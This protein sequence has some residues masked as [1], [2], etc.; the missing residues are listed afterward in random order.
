[1]KRILLS[2]LLA[3]SLALPALGAKQNVLD[4]KET[5]TDESIVYPETFERDTR[6]LLEGWYLKNYTATDDRYARQGDVEVSDETIKR[7][8]AALPTVIDMPYNQIVRDYI[9]RYTSRSREQVAAILGLGLYYTPIFEQALEEAGLP[10]ELKYLPVIES[11][12]DPNAVSKSGAAGLWQLMI[13]TAKGLG[14]EVNSLVDE[15]RDPYLSSE[16]AVA[17]LKDL[18]ET[19]GDWSLAIAAYNCGPGAVNKALRRAGGDPKSH[20]FWSI[21]QYLTPETRGYVPMFIAA[22]YVMNY[23]KEH[24]ISPVLASKPLVTDT[25]AVY[26][27]L[28]FNQISDVLNMPVDELRIL[29]PQF[30]ADVIPADSDRPYFLILP[31]Q[32]VHAYLVSEQE[33]FAHEADKYARRE[34]AEP[35]QDA[36][37]VAYEPAPADNEAEQQQEVEMVRKAAAQSSGQKAVTHKVASGETITSIAQQYGVTAADIK[38]WNNLRRNAVRTGQQLKIYT[39]GEV[40][41]QTAPAKA[42]EQPVAAANP[43][44]KTKK[45]ED[46]P[47]EQPVAKKDDKKSG[48]AGKANAKAEEQQAANAKQGKKG[49][50]AKA[51]QQAANTKQ[52]KKGKK[53]KQPAAP[54]NKDIEVKSGDNLSK[55][56]KRNGVSVEELRKANPKLKGDMLHPGDKITVPAKQQPAKGNGKAA[57]KGGKKKKK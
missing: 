56:A 3:A 15:R 29:N 31:S 32:Q 27:R 50:K 10:L 44:T 9:K 51:E 57:K 7:R 30:R 14:L 21:Y 17:Y 40:A 34:S 36:P 22:N 35:G 6:K 54:K 11:A 45:K 1:M 13:G 55:I 19:Y 47:K 4:L 52:G 16:K 2:T 18:Y 53:A 42:K 20:D 46:T 41:Q 39:G 37:A 12:L 43:K 25:V 23:H 5:I 38:E 28:H 26:N 33:I 48:K 8:L 49:K 24:N